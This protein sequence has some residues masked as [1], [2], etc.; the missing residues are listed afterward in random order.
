MDYTVHVIL[1][2][3]ILEWVTFPFSRGS[4][5][6]RDRTQVSWLQADS[7]LTEPPGKPMLC[8]FKNYLLSAAS[9]PISRALDGFQT[10]FTSL[11]SIE[12]PLRQICRP[13]H[14]T[15]LLWIRKL[16]IGD[17]ASFPREHTQ[18]GRGGTQISGFWFS[19]SPSDHKIIRISCIY[20]ST[21]T[22]FWIIA[23]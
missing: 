11:I 3:R 15:L 5:Q 16:R 19:P 18:L 9:S 8:P 4:S 21:Y 14:R 1:Q 12:L 10:S 22:F 20:I 7:L 2:A 23:F 17:V 6:P 13:S